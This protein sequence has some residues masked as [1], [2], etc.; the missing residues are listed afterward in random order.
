MTFWLNGEWHQEPLAI[1]IRDRGLLLG[2][3]VFETLLARSRKAL[4]LT[5]H[6]QRLHKALRAF[7]IS[8]ALLPTDMSAVL[9]ELIDRNGL[10]DGRAVIRLTVTRG[11]G[12]RGLRVSGTLEPTILITAVPAPVLTPEPFR[13][14]IARTHRAHGT[15]SVRHKCLAYSDNVLARREAELA[16]ADEAVML[17][18]NGSV[19]CASAAN[20]FTILPSGEVITPPVDDGALPGITRGVLKNAAHSAGISLEEQSFEPSLLDTATIFLTNSLIGVA[21]ASLVNNGPGNKSPVL[22]ELKTCYDRAVEREIGL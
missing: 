17:N 8:G 7:G 11:E 20:I 2:D 16:N 14:I 13:I 6:L 10:V 22:S 15:P 3:G 18:G 12:G 19:A 4:F 1:S 21:H 9:S 5:E